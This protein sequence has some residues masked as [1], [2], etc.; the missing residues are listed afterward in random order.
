MRIDVE[1]YADDL[2]TVD[3]IR[4]RNHIGSAYELAEMLEWCSPDKHF[5]VHKQTMSSKMSEDTTEAIV[6]VISNEFSEHEE[7]REAYTRLQNVIQD[8]GIDVYDVEYDKQSMSIGIVLQPF[9]I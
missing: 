1:K 7:A 8:I 9:D 5:D 2:S 4:L 6:P 3:S